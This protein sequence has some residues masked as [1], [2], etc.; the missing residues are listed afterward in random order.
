[1]EDGMFDDYWEPEDGPDLEDELDDTL[2]IQEI[3]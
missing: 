1:M 2:L 3:A